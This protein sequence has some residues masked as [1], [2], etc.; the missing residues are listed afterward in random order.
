MSRYFL[1]DDSPSLPASLCWSAALD[2]P[3]PKSKRPVTVP[4]R[5]CIVTRR[6]RPIASLLRFVVAPDGQIVLDLRRRLEGRGLWV[7]AQK[8]CVE[9]AVRTRAFAKSAGRPVV[10]PSDLALRTESLLRQR[11]VQGLSLVRKAGHLVGGFDRVAA[12]CAS[13][14]ALLILVASDGTARARK[15]ARDLGTGNGVPVEDRLAGE[16]LTQVLG[17]NRITFAALAQ[18]QAAQNWLGEWHGFRAF[19]SV[20]GCGKQGRHDGR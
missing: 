19:V 12:L 1:L 5:R 9:R 14:K 7:C 17:R 11:L 13:G 8:D 18:G 16:A 10:V 20:T 6:S 2:A 15:R 4:E 3:A